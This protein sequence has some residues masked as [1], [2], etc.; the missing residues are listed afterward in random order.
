MFGPTVRRQSPSSTGWLK[1]SPEYEANG[2]PKR[3]ISKTSQSA[4]GVSQ[5][6]HAASERRARSE[7]PEPDQ[8][9]ARTH[10]KST[11]RIDLERSANP[12]APPA[13]AARADALRVGTPSRVAR[14]AHANAPPTHAAWSGSDQS[15][16]A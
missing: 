13:S 12:A 9:T 1:R 16:P 4:A 8:S 2:R 6:A 3:T 10:G 15:D 5:P 11:M 14:A 7:R